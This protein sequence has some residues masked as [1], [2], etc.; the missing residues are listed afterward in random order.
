MHVN[1]SRKRVNMGRSYLYVSQFLPG[2][3]TIS[4][5]ESPSSN[6][7][8]MCLNSSSL[9]VRPSVNL[10][11]WWGWRGRLSERLSR[12][13]KPTNFLPCSTWSSMKRRKTWVSNALLYV[14]S[15]N[16]DVDWMERFKENR[17]KKTFKETNSSTLYAVSFTFSIV[18]SCRIFKQVFFR[19]EGVY[20]RNVEHTSHISKTVFIGSRT[21]MGA[22]VQ[23]LNAVT[24]LLTW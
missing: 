18:Q 2:I 13:T 12:R 20:A 14:F 16:K 10:P 11:S 4:A 7:F 17:K 22:L 5:I 9:C 19:N 23:Q 21:C 8:A 24:T 6:I 15:C 3:F 1:S